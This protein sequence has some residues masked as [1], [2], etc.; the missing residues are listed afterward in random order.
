LGELSVWLDGYVLSPPSAWDASGATTRDFPDLPGDPV[1]VVWFSVPPR[2]LAQLLVG[3]RRGK[4][5]DAVSEFLA[6]PSEHVRALA[7]ALAGDVLAAAYFDPDRPLPKGSLLLHMGVVDPKPIKT[8]LAKGASPG[9]EAS[10]APSGTTL[11][12]LHG[13]KPTQG[14][15]PILSMLRSR[16]GQGAFEKGHVSLFLDVGIL[17]RQLAAPSKVSGLSG[18]KLVLAKEIARSVLREWLPAEQVM[19]DLAP[20]TGGARIR[21][22]VR[23]RAR[24]KGVR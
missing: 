7:E 16:F 12:L 20:E 18:N 6:L 24:A 14:A 1:A 19:L 17:A 9:M 13:D 4:V 21:A 8:W 22:E 2:E 10:I 11:S 23:L 3:G 15:V 5:G